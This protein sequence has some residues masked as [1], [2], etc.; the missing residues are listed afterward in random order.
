MR[1]E[2]EY[3]DLSKEILSPME[4]W[5]IA[6][7]IKAIEAERERQENPT[8]FGFI[9]WLLGSITAFP[10]II[11][12]AYE[13]LCSASSF[14]EGVFIVIGTL[15]ALWLDITLFRVSIFLLR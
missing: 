12:L 1:D 3:K 4:R 5:T 8:T 6:S 11:Y 14:G 15:V 7:N 9:L 13:L 10:F 2:R